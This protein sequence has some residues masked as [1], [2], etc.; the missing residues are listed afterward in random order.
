MP[1]VVALLMAADARAGTGADARAARITGV[2]FDGHMRGDPE[3]EE[4]VRITN[5]DLDRVLDL[6]DFA[7]TDRFGPRRPLRARKGQQRGDDPGVV[8]ETVGEGSAEAQEGMDPTMGEVALEPTHTVRLPQGIR[9]PPGGE[10][11]IAHVGKA[12]KQV[13]GFPPGVEAADTLD[14]VPEATV[15][16]G[17]LNL[18]ANQGV[19]ALLSSDGR[20]LDVVAWDAQNPKDKKLDV[21]KIPEAQWVG[22]PVLLTDSSPFGWKGQVLARDRDEAGRVLADTDSAADW[23]SGFSRK[24]LGMEPTHRLEFPGQS[25]FVTSR[26]AGVTARVTCG[27]APENQFTLLAEA[28][29]QAKQRIRI[30]VYQLTNPLLADHLL[31]ALDRGVQVTLLLEGVPVGG[32]PDDER[33][34]LDGLAHRG[35]RVL[36]LAQREPKDPVHPRYRF[37]HAK[38]AL[39]DDRLAIIGTEN[40]G[41]TGHPADPSHG[42]RGFEVAIEEPGFVALLADVFET[43]TDPAHLDLVGIND[44]AFDPYG[45]PTRDPNFQLSKEFR[46]GLYP[47]RRKPLTVQG[48]MDLEIVMSPDNSLHEQSSILGMIARARRE[49]LVLQNSIPR[50]WGKGQKASDDTPNLALAAVLAAARRGV[51]VRVLMDGTWYNAEEQDARDN[52]DTARYLNE[53]AQKEGLNLSAKVINLETAHLEKIHAK[54]VMVDGEEVLVS[55]INWSEN[56]FKGNREMGVIIRHPDVTAYYRELFWRDWRASRLYRVSVRDNTAVLLAE[57]RN[58][59]PVIRRTNKGDWLDVVTEVPRGANRA[60]GY[61]EVPL[62]G[63]MSGYLRANAGGETL[64]TGRESRGLYGRQVTVEGRVME[65]VEKEKVL[66][67][68]LDKPKDPDF[69]L[70]FFKKQREKLKAAGA[71]PAVVYPGKKVRVRGTITRYKGPQIEVQDPKQVTVVE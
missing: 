29:D 36:F 16:P 22:Q 26:L 49:V 64:A 39:I 1:A 54:S 2:Y 42:N 47:E 23:D 61:L 48:K 69:Q 71:D 51:T 65:V 40:Y 43:D 25:R 62:E 50:F 52:D 38:Y 44:S 66:L 4:A 58:G 68:G 28:F 45:L 19:V 70:V 34:L 63:S 27:S 5:T 30:N 53:V 67:L 8:E 33:V 7:L 15:S 57:P 31:A 11:W 6:G 59:A 21:G 12:F 17:W 41:K 18:P 20:V 60:E 10:I 13:F 37:D 56:S 9:L 14:G 3:P 32:M 24:R 55:S 35:A 46:K